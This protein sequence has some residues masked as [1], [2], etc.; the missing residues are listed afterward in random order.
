MKKQWLM[1]LAASGVLAFTAQAALAQNIAVVN[2][3]PVTKARLDALT[4]QVAKSGRPVTPE[5]QAPDQRRAGGTRDLY[6][7]G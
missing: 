6:A 4:A 1:T 5:M 3:K 2:G 7:G